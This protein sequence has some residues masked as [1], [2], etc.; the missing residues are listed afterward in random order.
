[1][2]SLIRPE[3]GR[4]LAYVDWSSQEYGIG[5][6]L[7]GDGAMLAD[8]EVGDPYLGF[9]KRIGMVPDDATKQ[10][11]RQERNTVKAVILGTQYGM[12]EQALAIRI[13]GSVARARELLHLHRQTYRKFWAWSDAAVNVALFGGRIW[14]RF[15]WQTHPKNEPN[16]RSLANFPCQGNGADMLRLAAQFIV[17][18]GIQLDATVHDA[19]LIEADDDDLDGAVQ[20]AQDAM[21]KASR[22]VLDGF[23]LRTDFGITTWPDRYAD[24]RGATFFADLMTRVNVIR[25][26]PQ[27]FAYW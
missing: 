11:H 21:A 16:A 17:E 18:K 27:K 14:T 20:A 19:V 5:A 15:G 8:Y 12:G 23:E 2:R 9:A 1:M 13:G 25:N 4:A 3:Q 22:L 10:T 6:A 7:S 24:D 26:R